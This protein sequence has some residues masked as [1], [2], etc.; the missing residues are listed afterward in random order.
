MRGRAIGQSWVGYK[1]TPISLIAWGPVSPLAP[2]LGDLQGDTQLQLSHTNYHACNHASPIRFN[3]RMEGCYGIT[4]SRS[5]TQVGGTSYNIQTAAICREQATGCKSTQRFWRSKK[6]D[7]YLE[8]LRNRYINKPSQSWPPFPLIRWN[9]K[10][11]QCKLS[12]RI[13]DDSR[14]II[15]PR[16]CY[17][18]EDSNR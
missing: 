7:L 4:Q 5:N 15:S 12:E 18:L 8:R 17:S 6:I 1:A 16:D 10:V 11:C 2:L 13:E 3:R 9:L 14:L